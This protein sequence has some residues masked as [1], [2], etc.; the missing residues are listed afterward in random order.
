MIVNKYPKAHGVNVTELMR[1]MGVVL[2]WDWPQ[3]HLL[4]DNKYLEHKTYLVSLSGHPLS[5]AI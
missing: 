3:E 1:K 4:K 2:N 5:L